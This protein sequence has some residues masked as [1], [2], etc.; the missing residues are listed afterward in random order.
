ML[1]GWAVKTEERLSVRFTDT[2]WKPV[3]LPK[4]S[5]PWALEPC[6]RLIVLTGQKMECK[7]GSLLCTEYIEVQYSI[8][9]TKLNVHCCQDVSR[10]QGYL[11]KCRMFWDQMTYIV[12][13]S[14]DLAHTYRPQITSFMKIKGRE[15]FSLKNPYRKLWDPISACGSLIVLHSSWTDH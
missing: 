12:R 15:T 7:V 13:S 8:Y 1:P 2:R 4:G 11:T 3:L 14:L 9:R 5:C 10:R 6:R